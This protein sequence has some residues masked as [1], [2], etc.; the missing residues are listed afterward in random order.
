LLRDDPS[1]GDKA[2]RFSMLVKDAGE[3]LAGLGLTGKLGRLET[4]VTY[5]DPCHLAHG[6]RVRDQ[7][8]KLLRA[9]PGLE[10]KE[11]T[12]A[13][14]CCGSAGIYNITHPDMSRHLLQEKMQAIAATKAGAVVAPNPGC[15]LQL[16]YGAREFGPNLTVYHLM[17]LLDRSYSQAD[18]AE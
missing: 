5:Q 13:D 18:A 17:D 11:M 10:L 3:F 8:R 9:I 1:Y 7:P 16:R 4:T 6:Q 14:H 12:G 15:M 2:K